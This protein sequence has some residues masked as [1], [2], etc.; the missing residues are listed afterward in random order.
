MAAFL[1]ELPSTDADGSSICLRITSH[2]FDPIVRV[3][4]VANGPLTPTPEPRPIDD[5][6]AFFH[7]S[8][9]VYHTDQRGFDSL[10]RSAIEAFPRADYTDNEDACNEDIIMGT[11]SNGA[12]RLMQLE[13]PSVVCVAA[14][15]A[16]CVV[17]APRRAVQVVAR[18]RWAEN[19]WRDETPA[20]SV[21]DVSENENFK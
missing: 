14:G 17:A 16:V 11:R 1:N 18:Y 4:S 5:A 8:G 10:P 13:E 21:V 3:S 9:L 2:T 12:C 6:A 20:A 7:N 15:Q 19:G